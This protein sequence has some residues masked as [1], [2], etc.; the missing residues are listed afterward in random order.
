MRVA[1]ACTALFTIVLMGALALVGVGGLGAVATAFT[2]VDA[3]LLANPVIIMS[4][5][6][7]LPLAKLDP[8]LLANPI[9]VMSDE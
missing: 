2:Q 3:R 1:A 9:I 5:E 4:D 6:A 8:R 7:F